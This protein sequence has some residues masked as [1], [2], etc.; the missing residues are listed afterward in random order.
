M[1]GEGIAADG[2][3]RVKICGITNLADALA[4]IDRGA[5]ALGFNLFPGSKRHID[6]RS[7]ADWMAALPKHVDR[8]AVLVN[9]S[10]NE[11]T[12]AAAWPFIDALQLHGNE[13]PEFCERL[14]GCGIRFA[15]V[16][17]VPEQG[18][19]SAVPEFF[20]DLLMLDAASRGAFGG[21]G[22]TFPWLL[23]RHFVENHPEHKVIVA[24]GLTSA[25][26]SE[27]IRTIRPFGVDVTTGVELSPG[28]KDP[29][30]LRA[31]LAAVRNTQKHDA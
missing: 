26:V 27:A 9:P 5:D 15:K 2:R 7:E 23:G 3:V 19:L 13:S 28:R 16:V 8:V 30:R 24:G 14:T 11:A 12:R 31:F 10:W 6:L 4:A 22:Q 25:N 18:F 29:R 17:P 21:T 1:F 20:T